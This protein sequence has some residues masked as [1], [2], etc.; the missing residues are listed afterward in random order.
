MIQPRETRNLT[1]RHARPCRETP[2]QLRDL[3][4]V[5]GETRL[6]LEYHLQ[7]GFAAKRKPREPKSVESRRHL[8]APVDGAP[9]GPIA[10]KQQVTMHE[11]TP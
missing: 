1:S 6:A 9:I 11:L 7:T 4:G 2:I 10:Q 3:V 5:G 8:T